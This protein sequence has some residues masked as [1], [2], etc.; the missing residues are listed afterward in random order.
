MHTSVFYI[1]VYCVYLL[2]TIFFL[3]SPWAN[4]N[5]A[6]ITENGKNYCLCTLYT[7]IYVRTYI[8]YSQGP[9]PQEKSM[10]QISNTKKNKVITI[11]VSNIVSVQPL[12]EDR[13]FTIV[14]PDDNELVLKAENHQLLVLW[15]AILKVAISK[16][17]FV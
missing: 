9:F 1:C 7:Y 8:F 4:R 2:I 17:L 15:T 11:D 14:L 3:Q 5:V 16:G 13:T 6:L 10:L 12:V